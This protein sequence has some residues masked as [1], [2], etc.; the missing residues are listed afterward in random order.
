[1]L[2]VHNSKYSV[3]EQPIV[4]SVNSKAGIST[5]RY[6]KKK[7]ITFIL[8]VLRILF[9]HSLDHWQRVGESSELLCYILI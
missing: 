6:F 9:M 5:A 8:I 2:L 7:I 3:K 4:T 1:V